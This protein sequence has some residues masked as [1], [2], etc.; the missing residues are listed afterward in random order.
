[1]RGIPFEVESS[2]GFSQ[3]RGVVYVEDEDLVFEVQT[4]YIGF[5]QRAPEVYR[6]ELTDLDEVRYKKGFL[7]DRVTLRTR[8]LE[9]LTAVPGA[10]QG[11]LRLAVKRTHRGDLAVLL[12]RLDLWRVD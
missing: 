4:T 12:D 11:E 10:A 3:S 8:P 6:V 5:I 2:G 1:M 7:S 9:K